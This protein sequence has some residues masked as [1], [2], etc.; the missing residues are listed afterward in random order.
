VKDQN[1]IKKSDGALQKKEEG[2][3]CFKDG[4]LEIIHDL[5]V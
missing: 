2:A 5:E 3:T 4:I 1:I